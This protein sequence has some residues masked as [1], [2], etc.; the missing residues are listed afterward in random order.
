MKR[1]HRKALI[2]FSAFFLVLFTTTFCPDYPSVIIFHTVYPGWQE[3]HGNLKIVF[4]RTCISVTPP[5]KT[6]IPAN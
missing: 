3:E 6:V 4:F 5:L 2:S 1:Q